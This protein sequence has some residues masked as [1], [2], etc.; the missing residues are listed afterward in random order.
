MLSSPLFHLHPLTRTQTHEELKHVNLIHF[1]EYF[2][3]SSWKA[4]KVID[5]LYVGGLSVKSLTSA[6]DYKVNFQ[7]G[8]QTSETGEK[9]KEAEAEGKAEEVKGISLLVS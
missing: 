4:I 8:C 3:G 2:S 1:F 7:F 6:A 5:T 9:E